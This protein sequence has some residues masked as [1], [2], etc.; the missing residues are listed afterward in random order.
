MNTQDKKVLSRDKRVV[1][2]DIL[3]GIAVVLMT[4]DH[5]RG[6]FTFIPYDPENILTSSFH[7]FFSRWVT[8]LAAPIFFLLSGVG[9]SYSR[10]PKK[11]QSLNL[12]KRGLFLILVE[13]LYINPAWGQ[14]L[15]KGVFI[16]VIFALGCSMIFLAVAI[17]LRLLICATFCVAVVVGHNL[18]DSFHFEQAGQ[19]QFLWFLLHERQVVYFDEF[20]FLIGYPIFPWAAVMLA[21]FILGK[22]RVIEKSS[23]NFKYL[24]LM[25]LA[26]FSIFRLLGIYGEPIEWSVFPGSPL[27]TMFSFLKVSKYPP[28]L[29]YLLLSFGIV[30]LILHHIYL[31]KGRLGWVLQVL[32]KTSMFFYLAHLPLIHFLS[33]IWLRMRTG[34]WKEWFDFSPASN[35]SIENSFLTIFVSWIFVILLL[36]PCMYLFDQYKSTKRPWWGLYI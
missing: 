7:W 35:L 2:I 28:S 16:Q 18:L 32:G 10:L 30:F 34:H 27:K 19:L 3:R 20:R 6:F 33:L 14:S 1:S 24:G 8:H 31:L 36:F 23:V 25:L 22:S 29:A 21:G 12:V 13:I 4:L 15:E 17:H 11:V 5:T 9:A 26:A